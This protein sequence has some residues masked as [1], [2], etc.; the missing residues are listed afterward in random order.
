MDVDQIF[1]RYEQEARAFRPVASTLGG[2]ESSVVDARFTTIVDA[3]Y[4]RDDLGAPPSVCSAQV[5]DDPAGR[6]LIVRRMP[7]ARSGRVTAVA[8]VL[9][10]PPSAVWGMGLAPGWSGWLGTE[11]P[12]GGLVRLAAADL[13][14]AAEDG[15][16]QALRTIAELDPDRGEDQELVRLVDG[17]LRVGDGPLA[18]L[19]GEQDPM[20]LLAGA[21]GVLRKLASADWSFSTGE[22]EQKAGLRV[23]FMRPGGTIHSDG[24]AD[25]RRNPE[26]SPFLGAAQALVAAYRRSPD[27]AFWPGELIAAGVEDLAGLLAW[28]RSG[29]R[30]KPDVEASAAAV[31]EL[32]QARLAWEREGARLAEE[33]A[34]ARR[35]VTVL[36]GAAAEA[37]ADARVAREKAAADVAGLVVARDQAQAALAREQARAAE[38]LALARAEVAALRVERERFE[39]VL[40]GDRRRWDELLARQRHEFEGELARAAEERA[41]E[42]AMAH[43]ALEGERARAA[44]AEERAE[45]R[46]RA[47]HQAE[48]HMLAL[49]RA[50]DAER[51]AF[52]QTVARQE[53][54]SREAERRAWRAGWEDGWSEGRDDLH[55]A[56]LAWLT[57]HPGTE[58]RVPEPEPA[59]EWTPA[60]DAAPPDPDPREPAPEDR[61]LPVPADPP[62]PVPATE[63]DEVAGIQPAGRE[64]GAEPAGPE[65]TRKFRRFGLPGVPR[66][67]TLLLTGA[68]L[69]MTGLFAMT[70]RD[71][72]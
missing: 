3:A 52:T 18:V 68:I 37:E 56:W 47:L 30:G 49:T 71:S 12:A 21:R 2:D 67:E 13:V 1:F 53:D 19:P 72:Q 45:A 16:R 44:E 9:V 29:A 25:L 10:G 57:S 39:E 50:L 27:P 46:T 20:V 58:R 48:E 36:E 32:N 64:P 70:G 59:P 54:S 22:P 55:A 23:T 43:V 15:L 8:H 63:P 40:V 4:R 11:G 17:L 33:L 41:A 28:A 42:R 69:A 24:R 61:W 31:A 6:A 60:G 62:A 65:T 5:P 26:S 38:D 7:E 51:E 66:P 34:A 35:A 14:T